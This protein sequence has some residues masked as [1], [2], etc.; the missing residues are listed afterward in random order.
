[1]EELIGLGGVAG[2]AVV[3]AIVLLIRQSISLPDRYIAALA[4]L[5]GIVLNVALRLAT[6]EAAIVEEVAEPNWAATI[7]TGF[8]AGLAATG[9][10]EGQKAIRNGGGGPNG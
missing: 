2:A 10:W 1:M 6:E 5:V 3:M 8:L 9:L 7:L 4:V